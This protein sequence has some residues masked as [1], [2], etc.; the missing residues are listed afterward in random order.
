M[1]IV[2]RECGEL[3]AD[4]ATTC[5]GCG[6]PL[7]RGVSPALLVTAVLGAVLLVGVFGYVDWRL[8]LP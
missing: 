2:C 6:V 7:R 5:P 4:R 1:L 8:H 3:V